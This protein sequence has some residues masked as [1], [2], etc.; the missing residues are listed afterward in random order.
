M[1]GKI[2]GALLLWAGPAPS[3]ELTKFRTQIDVLDA[4]I[5]ALLN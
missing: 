2:L 3:P 1:L 5:V 4:Q